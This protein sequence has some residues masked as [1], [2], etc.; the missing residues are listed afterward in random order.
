MKFREEKNKHPSREGEGSGIGLALIKELAQLMGGKIHVASKIGEGTRFTLTLPIHHNAPK[1]ENSLPTNTNDHKQ[2]SLSARIDPAVKTQTSDAENLPLLLIIEDNTDVAEYLITC[3]EDHYALIH[4]RDG[5]EGIEVALEQ[6]PDLIISDV[7]MPYKDGFEVCQN[8]KHDDRTSHIPIILLTARADQESR[9]QGLKRGADAYLAKPFHKEELLVRLETLFEFRRKLQARYSTLEI[10]DSTT[11]EF[12]YEDR[13]IT[14]IHQI[15][16]NNLTK[17]DFNVPMLC[18][19]IGMSRTSLHRKIKAL[20]GK[21]ITLFIRRYRI[22]KAEK[23][24]KNTNL[25]ISE[26]AYQLGFND[27]AHF[28]RSFSIE[29]G[30]SPTKM[31]EEK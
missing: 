15:L 29:F 2:T 8:L 21:S 25:P 6:I 14:R 16:E 12:E 3:L 20:T 30:M 26:I 13:F 27:P 31:R 18:K 10:T 5:Q 19:L 24:I 22:I 4:A 1:E 11:E 28:S 23:L 17:T 7:M 9:I